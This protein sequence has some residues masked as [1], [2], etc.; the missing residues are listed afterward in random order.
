M[1]IHIRPMLEITIAAR[2][3]TGQTRKTEQRR[4][5]MPGDRYHKRF[6][7]IESRMCSNPEDFAI[8]FTN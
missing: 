3:E 5:I 7:A 1:R 6:E 8:T 4:Q 2:H